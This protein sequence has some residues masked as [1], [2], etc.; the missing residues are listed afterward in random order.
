[1]IS[2]A[3][4]AQPGV[5]PG[6]PPACDLNPAWLND[7]RGPRMER[8]SRAPARMTD[9]PAGTARYDLEVTSVQSPSGG[10][11]ALGDV[12]A[13]V[14]GTDRPSAA[15]LAPGVQTWLASPEDGLKAAVEPVQGAHATRDALR[16]L[17]PST[18]QVLASVAD[19]RWQRLTLPT[20]DPIATLLA[21]ATRIQEAG[22]EV[23]DFGLRRPSLDDVFLALTGDDHSTLPSL[24]PAGP[25]GSADPQQRRAVA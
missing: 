1:M 3:A 6:Q 25:V 21:A 24:T 11:T 14:Q 7:I 12:I 13:L 5:V 17:A 19:L 10:G 18:L 22:I 16:R 4:D 20:S 2:A 15:D 8:G 23:E 9:A